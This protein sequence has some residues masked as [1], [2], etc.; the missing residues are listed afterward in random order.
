[1]IFLIAGTKDGRELAGFLLQEGYEVTASVISQYGKQLAEQYEGIKVNDK[2]LDENELVA[3][4]SQNNIT[5]LVDASHPYAVNVSQN[6]M[7]A[8]HKAN[9]PYIRYERAEVP[10]E[11]DKLYTVDS[12]E[13]AAEL[14]GSL[15]KSIF[16]TTGSRNVKAFT[17][18]PHLKECFI[19]ARILPTADVIAEVTALGLTPENIIALQGPFSLELNKALFAQYHADVIVTKDSGFVGGADKKF[20]AAREMNLPVVM[21]ARPKLNYDKLA[22]TFS[23]IFD[24]LASIKG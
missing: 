8:A 12:Y 2:P 9:I 4:L 3:Y 7:N 17:T 21:I 22:T 5:A 14:A 18:S 20:E 13:K 24:F 16:L 1:M 23:E 19:A 11:Y 6:A 15:G 10:F